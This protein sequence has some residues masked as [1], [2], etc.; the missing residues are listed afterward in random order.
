MTYYGEEIGMTDAYISWEETVDPEGCR[1]GKA[2]YQSTS[3]DPERTPFQW[4]N[5]VAAG[6]FPTRYIGQLSDIMYIFDINP[7]LRICLLNPRFI[8]TTILITKSFNSQDFPQIP[9]PGSQSTRITR[10]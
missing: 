3:R 5:S 9:I 10:P 8:P 2:N 1:A 7:L 4:D 6:K